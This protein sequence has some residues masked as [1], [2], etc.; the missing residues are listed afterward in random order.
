MISYRTICSVRSPERRL[1]RRTD[2]EIASTERAGPGDRALRGIALGSCA[3]DLVADDILD[4]RFVNV[5]L[6]IDAAQISTS[7]SRTA[8]VVKNADLITFGAC[9]TSG[10]LGRPASGWLKTCF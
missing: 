5:A 3:Q 6:P 2:A 8:G 7:A 4:R 9:M 10:T 1:I